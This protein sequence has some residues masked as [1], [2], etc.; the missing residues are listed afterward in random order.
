MKISNIN[1][2]NNNKISPDELK[3]FEKEN[4][5]NIDIIVVAAE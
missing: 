1:G 4:T 5:H 2:N 3:L